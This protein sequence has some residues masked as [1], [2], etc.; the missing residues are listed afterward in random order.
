MIREI[1][2]AVGNGW[3]WNQAGVDSLILPGALIVPE[4]EE[5]VLLDGSANRAP[6]LVLSVKAAVRR[7]EVA[8]V[9][10]GVPKKL[11]AASM[12]FIGSCL[13]E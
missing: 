13:R 1:A 5:S 7:K 12:D 6:E 10:I 8:R 2:G 3:D 9:E 11:E 4:K